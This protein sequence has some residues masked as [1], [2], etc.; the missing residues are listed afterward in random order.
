MK[1]LKTVG[2]VIAAVVLLAAGALA[3]V[4]SQFDAERIAAEAAR[5]VKEKTQRD[6]RIDGGLR[7]GFWPDVALAVGKVSL[8]EPGTVQTFASVDSARLSVAVMPLLSR[9]V[10]VTG[11]EVRGAKAALFRRK[12]GTLNVSDLLPGGGAPVGRPEART[13]SP[14]GGE[15]LQLDVAGVHIDGA[16]LTWRDQGSGAAASLSGLQLKSGRVRADTGAKAYSIEA[17][18][19]AMNGRAG[20]DTFELKLEVPKLD[21]TRG[22]SGAGS[23][24]FTGTFTGTQRNITARL[25]LSG[26]EGTA[27]VLNVA[28]LALDLD[29]KSGEVGVK[30]RLE[31]AIAAQLGTQDIKLERIAGD[32][33]IAHPR[34]PKGQLK[35]PV[36]GTLHAELAKESVQ[37]RLSTRFDGSNLAL[38]F[39]VSGFAAPGVSFKLDADRFNFDRY[40]TPKAAGQNTAER[41]GEQ[42]ETK[43]DFSPLK[44]LNVDGALSV[45][46]LQA[47]NVKAIDVR[48]R[49]RAAG[50][51]LNVAPISAGLYQGTVS[52]SLAL[53]ANRSTVEMKQ[54]L[55]NVQI[56][57]LLRDAADKDI[58]EGRGNVL[59]D[60]RARGET[61][62]AMKRSLEGSASVKLRD[63]AVK[64]INLAQSFR[65]LKAKFSR[66]QDAVQKAAAKDKT[67]FSELSATFKIV[68]GVARNDDLSAKSPFLRLAGSG[69]IDIGAGRLNYLA[70]AS[71]VATAGGQG[72]KDL[73]YLKGVTVPVRLT[74]P[75]EQPS[76]RIELSGLASE[77]LKARV[78]EKSKAV[79]R[80]A[81]DQIRNRLK[82][83]F[84]R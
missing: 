77:A 83:L 72:A 25:A 43:L 11:V 19:L 61:V 24:T 75:F 74:G 15:A 50:G 68:D 6:L 17:L 71:V 21:L 56:G 44:T 63:G 20:A 60:V 65:E 28:R 58:I 26:V 7:L 29:G 82:G 32:F 62:S 64:G 47:A 51:R 66:R 70:K 38:A 10:V 52:G 45:G 76:W 27:D 73:E 33:V 9:K 40:T 12:D 42:S 8:S 18:T 36:S 23:M 49:A 69:D 48:L 1:Y 59:I 34:M 53:D 46:E 16:A 54:D 31:S 84:G 39:G 37:G 22:K 4:A 67:D 81:E 55:A 57:P 14:Q 13:E 5:V 79:R 3:Y 41:A 80:K 78:E 2:I 35:M 30:G